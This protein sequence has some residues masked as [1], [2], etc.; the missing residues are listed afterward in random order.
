MAE[1]KMRSALIAMLLCV[2]SA[3]SEA[4]PLERSVSQEKV[5]L[6]GTFL[7]ESPDEIKFPVKVLFAVDCSL[8][9][10]DDVDGMRVGSDP[11]D[12]RIEAVRNFIQTYHTADYPNVSFEIMLWNNG[13]FLQSRNGENQPGFTR[14]AEELNQVLDAVRNDAMTDY[15]GTLDAIRADIENDIRTSTQEAGGT[16]NLVRTKYIVVFLSDGIPDGQ[17]G[18]QADGD[19]WQKSKKLMIWPKK[20]GLAVLTSTPF[21]CWAAS[22]PQSPARPPDSRP[23]SPYRGWPSAAAASFWSLKMPRPLISSISPICI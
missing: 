9:M 15:L 16:E 7:T 4:P 2:V 6:S 17:G 20:T 14:S 13:V 5:T 22:D 12:L 19:I 3:C 23:P 11:Y 10:G 1:G 21:C 18:T 8:S